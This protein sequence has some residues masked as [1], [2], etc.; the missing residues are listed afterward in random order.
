MEREKLDRISEL[1]RL[2]RQRK[3]TAGEASE[4]QVLRQEYL[5]EWRRGAEAVLENTCLVDDKG[6]K[7]KLRKKEDK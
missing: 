3:L 6:N 1:C 5:A 2:A 4:Q 7:R